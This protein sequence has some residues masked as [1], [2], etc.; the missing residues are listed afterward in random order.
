MH[1]VSCVLMKQAFSPAITHYPKALLSQGRNLLNALYLPI[2]EY[3]V[4]PINKPNSQL[5]ML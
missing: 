5:L 4:V 2:S 1:Y 3:A